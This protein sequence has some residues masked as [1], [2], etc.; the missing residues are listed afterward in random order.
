M[1]QEKAVRV[2][3]FTCEVYTWGRRLWYRNGPGSWWGVGPRHLL[4]SRGRD[5]ERRAF[6]G[7][8]CDFNVF[9]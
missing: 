7:F 9:V 2:S 5:V 3:G 1:E 4:V 8:S 6:G